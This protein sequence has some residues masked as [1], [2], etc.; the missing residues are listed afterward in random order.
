[1]PHFTLEPLTPTIG[2]VV[3]G[4][5]LSAPLPA[6]AAAELRAALVAWRVLFAREQHLDPTAQ[7]AFGRVFGELTP[8]HPL[9]GG[10]DDDHPEVLVLDSAAYALGIG[11]RG[12]GTSYNNRWHTDVTFSATPPRASVLAARVV[13]DVGGDTLWSDLV[14]AYAALSAPVRALADT[15]TA[16]H[17][18]AQ[19][20][21]RF[22]G[23]DDGRNRIAALV[24]VRHPVV[25]LNP[26]SGDRG[27]FVNPVFTSHIDG[28]TRIES[29]HLL[30]LFYEQLARPEHV[31]RWRWRAG[32]VAIWDNRST[33]HY[34]TAD[35]HE[36]RV[37][38]RVTVAGEPPLGVTPGT[39][40]P[41]RPTSG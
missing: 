24:P 18:A 22:R 20:F 41:R 13:P 38:H 8:A 7:V 25:R 37:M 5:D 1:M 14:G 16:V 30:A 34:A 33:A 36:R 32:D 17:D 31:V 6:D 19:T 15:L 29:D 3:G 27:L 21:D 35:Y 4:L 23:D 11:D 9:Q 2:A 10:I 28:L 12:E 26:D 39:A 40:A